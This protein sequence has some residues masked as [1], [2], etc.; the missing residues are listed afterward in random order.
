MKTVEL[1][2]LSV[3][4]L[5]TRESELRRKL[6]DLKVRHSTAVLDSTAE[7]RSLRRDIARVKTVRR[8]KGS[9]S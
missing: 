6:F 2:D 3:E 9:E 4:E 8:E 7:L 5:A 1:R